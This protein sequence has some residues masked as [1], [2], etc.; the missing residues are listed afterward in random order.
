MHAH[1]YAQVDMC[2]HAICIFVSSF[3]LPH[4]LLASY[5]KYNPKVSV[6]SLYASEL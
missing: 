6:I 1:G 2:R 5:V 4:I 3:L